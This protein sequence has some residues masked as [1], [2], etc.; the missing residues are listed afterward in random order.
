VEYSFTL[1]ELAIYQIV[2]T[3]KENQYD[4]PVKVEALKWSPESLPN[5]RQGKCTGTEHKLQIQK[6]LKKLR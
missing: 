5:L 6:I 2:V 3:G 1:P 4:V